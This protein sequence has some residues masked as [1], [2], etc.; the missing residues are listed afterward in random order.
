MCHNREKPLYTRMANISS[1]LGRASTYGEDDI[2]EIAGKGPLGI[3]ISRTATSAE[4]PLQALQLALDVISQGRTV[5]IFLIGDG[6]YLAKNGRTETA[7]LLAQLISKGAKIFVSPE[8]LKA[9]GLSPNALMPGVLV[10]E[11][12]Y[13]DLVTFVME[14]HEKVVPC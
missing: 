5:D 12:T 6:I 11:D 8:H 3:M 9:S 13:R 10:V 4:N 2:V 7:G 1:G 14:D